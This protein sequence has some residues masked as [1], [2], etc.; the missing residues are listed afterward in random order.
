MISFF[1]AAQSAMKFHLK[2]SGVVQRQSAYNGLR[3]M[4]KIKIKNNNAINGLMFPFQ[5]I[6]AF[7]NAVMEDIQNFLL[8]QSL[9]VEE[10]ILLYFLQL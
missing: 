4:I 10:S 2:I 1:I 7:T 3:T 8:K 5:K 6:N 9:N